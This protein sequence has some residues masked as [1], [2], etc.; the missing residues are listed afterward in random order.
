MYLGL[1]RTRGLLMVSPAPGKYVGTEL[2]DVFKAAEAWRKAHE[3]RQ[4][5][6][7]KK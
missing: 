6:K 1:S 3:E 5:R 4:P 7:P 2:K